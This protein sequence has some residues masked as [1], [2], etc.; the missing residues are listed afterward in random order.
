M[1]RKILWTLQI[2]ILL[3]QNVR[4]F[5]LFFSPVPENMVYTDILQGQTLQSSIGKFCFQVTV[6]KAALGENANWEPIRLLP[7]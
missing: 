2:G 7:P 1:T 5:V 4:L 6:I 3:P